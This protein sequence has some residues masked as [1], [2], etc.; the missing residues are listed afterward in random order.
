MSANPM[1]DKIT[2]TISDFC[3]L[4]GIGRTSVYEMISDGRLQSVTIGRR[5]LVIIE[6]YRALLARNLA[7]LRTKNGASSGDP[8]SG[9]PQRRSRKP[10]PKSARQS[11]R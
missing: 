6:S 5:R 2:T 9:A 7:P 10:G 8:S 11:A 4:S 1:E 3:R